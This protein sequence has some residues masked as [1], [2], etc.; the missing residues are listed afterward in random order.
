MSEKENSN[1]TSNYAKMIKITEMYIK[2]SRTFCFFW[3][4]SKGI[5]HKVKAKWGHGEFNYGPGSIVPYDNIV[6]GGIIE[7]NDYH[8]EIF[9]IIQKKRLEKEKSQSLLPELIEISEI[10]TKG[11]DTFSFFWFDKEGKFFIVKVDIPLYRDDDNRYSSGSLIPK[12]KVLSMEEGTPFQKDCYYKR[13]KKKQLKTLQRM[14]Y[15]LLLE[16]SKNLESVIN[17]NRNK[18]TPKGQRRINAVQ[19]RIKAKTYSEIAN[20]LHVNV[21]TICRDIGYL[22]RIENDRLLE[23]LTDKPHNPGKKP[24]T[25]SIKEKVKKMREEHKWSC[26]EISKQLKKQGTTVSYTA[27]HKIIKEKKNEVRTL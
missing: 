22:K 13:I 2:G 9:K 8:W 1:Y 11:R 24:I 18:I 21:S 5:L 27:V 10:Y 6:S 20:D 15:Q 12:D 19:L 4:N 26:R 14:G 16:K 3:L 23:F 7:A 17:E 25:E